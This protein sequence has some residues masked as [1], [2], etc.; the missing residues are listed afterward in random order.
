MSETNGNNTIWIFVRRQGF[1]IAI[2][3]SAVLAIYVPMSEVKQEVALNN[4]K[5]DRLITWTEAHDV[6][7]QTMRQQLNLVFADIFERLGAKYGS[8]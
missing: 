6:S 4:Q 2:V 7:H 8:F 1:L 3:I 5:L